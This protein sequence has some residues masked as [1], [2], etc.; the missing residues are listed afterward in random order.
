MIRIRL[1]VFAIIACVIIAGFCVC[2]NSLGYCQE[3][4]SETMRGDVDVKY[5]A[6]KGEEFEIGANIYGNA[7]FKDPDAAFDRML[8]ECAD[9]IALIRDEFNLDDLTKSNYRAYATYGWQVTSGTESAKQEALFVTSV[10]DIYEN[11]RL[12]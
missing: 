11:S 4:D 1:V 2:L 3:Y 5:F 10:L 8:E 6:D 9:G 7:V 12:F